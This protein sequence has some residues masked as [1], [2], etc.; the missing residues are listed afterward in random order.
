MVF[1]AQSTIAVISHTERDRQKNR[2]TDRQTDRMTDR[3]LDF[4]T[5]ILKDSDMHMIIID[6]RSSKEVLLR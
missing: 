2:Q 5:V 3:E 4:K 1:Y 6:V